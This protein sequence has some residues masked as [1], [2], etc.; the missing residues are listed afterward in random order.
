MP[1]VLDSAG[2][3]AALRELAQGTERIFRVSCPFRCERPVQVM[4][5]KIATQ[6]FRI[7]QEAVANA[8]KHSHADRIEISLNRD[9]E[10]L[11]LI[12]RDNGIGIPDNVTGRRT[13]MGLLTMSHR[14]RM[15]GGSLTASSDENGGTLVHCSVPL[16]PS[17]L[18]FL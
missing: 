1:V 7:A 15:V 2:L 14:A 8:I 12:I 6:L 13:G 3:M 4:D 11:V 16:P 18:A 5:N 9:K 17:N 10:Q